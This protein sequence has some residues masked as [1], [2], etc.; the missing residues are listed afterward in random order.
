MTSPSLYPAAGRLLGALTLVNLLNYVDRQILFAVYPEIQRDLGLVDSQLGLA[1]SAF[2]VVYMLVTPIAGRLGDR[3]P[4]LRVVAGGLAVWSLAT[5]LAG[6]A[7]GF[8]SLLVFRG[9]V[10]VGEACY[11]PLGSAMISDAYPPERRGHTLSI[12]NI[13]VPVGSALG[14]LLG[15]LLGAWFGW[16]A[17]FFAVGAPGLALAVVLLTFDE[18]TRGGSEPHGL[19]RDVGATVGDLARDPLY[20]VVTLSMAALTFVLGALAAWMPTFLVRLHDMS[21]SG[22]GVTFGIVT[23]LAGVVGT[24]LGGWLGDRAL[25]RDPRGHLQVSAAGLLLAVPVT[26][27]AI[28]AESPSIFWGATAVAEVLL[29][30]NVGP[31]NAVIVGAAAPSIRAT[32]VAANILVI[33]LLGDALSPW[34][35]GALSDRFGL[36]AALVV[37]PPM[38][39]LSAVLCLFAGR[40][41]RPRE[42]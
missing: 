13:A 2:I 8:G 10:G 4:R 42:S 32:A 9:L 40:Y 34:A 7:W 11:A 24:M 39:L 17:A 12:F 29:F 35:V 36:R 14:Y 20:V 1:G 38:L 15:G 18:P 23:A 19:T 27:L 16:R 22:A 37:M 5:V 26:A 41:V 6:V 28:F 30:L 31:L 25:R 33:H 3:L 21:I